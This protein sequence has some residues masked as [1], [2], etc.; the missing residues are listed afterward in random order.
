MDI[1]T[2]CG[3]NYKKHEPPN[4]TSNQWIFPQ[5]VDS[6]T[7]NIIQTIQEKTTILITNQIHQLAF[8]NL[9]KKTLQRK[10]ILASFTWQSGSTGPNNSTDSRNTKT[11][12]APQDVLFIPRNNTRTIMT[13]H[14]NHWPTKTHIDD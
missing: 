10:T 5:L 8:I 14:Y 4:S 7:T 6:A 2:T 12:L 3:F 9:E 1:S 11:P 13:Y